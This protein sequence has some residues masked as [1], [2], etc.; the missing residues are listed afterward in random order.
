MLGGYCGIADGS[1]GVTLCLLS[2]YS[3]VSGGYCVIANGSNGVYSGFLG[4][5]GGV[6]ARSLY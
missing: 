1:N 3:G 2:D 4:G 5:C 6:V